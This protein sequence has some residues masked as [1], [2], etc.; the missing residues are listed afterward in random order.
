LVIVRELLS[1]LSF[2]REQERDSVPLQV[3]GAPDGVFALTV[4]ENGTS[5]Y[6]G[7]EMIGSKTSCEKGSIVNG[8]ENPVLLL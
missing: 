8:S 1:I 5:T 6:W 2:P 7:D 3:P 4:I